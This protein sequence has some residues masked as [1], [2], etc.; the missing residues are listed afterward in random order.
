[1]SSVS[2]ISYNPDYFIHLQPDGAML[3]ERNTMYYYR[4]SGVA[5]QL[6][7]LLSKTKSLKK[8]ASI[9][10]NMNG[11]T[12]SEEQLI[13][14]LDM[15]P[16]T[17]SWKDGVLDK[18]RLTGST[19]S[20]LPISCTLQ[21]TNGCN[22]FCSFCYA[23]SGKPLEK[24]LNA[25]DWLE[26]LQKLA[27]H[28]VTDITLTGGEARLAKGFKRIITTAST[29]F[30][31]VHLFSNGLFWKDDEVELISAL[32]NIFV[33]VS[34]DG[35]AD[36]HD[37]LRGK[38]GAYIE[39]MNSVHKLASNGVPCLIAMTVNPVNYTD[40]ES[41]IQ[42]AVKAGAK[43]FR[44]GVTLPV[45]RADHNY[46]EL[47]DEQYTIV[48]SKLKEAVN[49]FGDQLFI[50]DWSNDG[51]EG[52]NDFCTPGYLAW[53][54]RADGEVTPCQIEDRSLG[55]ILR[56]SFHEIGTPERL[57]QAQK[58]AKSCKCIAKV[59]LPQEADLPFV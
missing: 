41:V 26:I 3:V 11:I 1:V 51:N 4:L 9:W 56:D 55:H 58:E 30:A 59:M 46:F 53:Y 43:A 7:L 44:A 14:E 50:T 32:G 31:N 57:L 12:Y 16:L 29:L 54:I 8:T 34:V 36:T 17:E 45:G 23:S 10:A 39:S 42:D 49:C 25:E 2:S 19:K 28:G 27:A 18:L 15:H 40:I 38:K 21:L 48:D 24:E 20:Y 47:S 22:L 37:K 6:A 35:S 33:Q 52:C 13:H 5:T